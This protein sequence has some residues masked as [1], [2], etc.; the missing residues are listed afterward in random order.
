MAGAILATGGG[1][2]GAGAGGG[3]VISPAPV[4]PNISDAIIGATGDQTI[5]GISVPVSLTATMTGGGVLYY[6]LNDGT[7]INYAGAFTVHNGD[8]LNW[9]VAGSGV[10]GS[11]TVNNQSN[12]GA[13][14]ATFTYVVYRKNF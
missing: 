3:V 12:G 14:V 1:S 11:V 5:S 8:K 9:L 7:V 4:W 10:S 6:S 2:V 13:T